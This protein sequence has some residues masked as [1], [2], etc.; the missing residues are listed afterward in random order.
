MTTN[1]HK[2]LDNKRVSNTFSDS[3]I[4]EQ[5]SYKISTNHPPTNTR[6]VDILQEKRIKRGRFTK[7]I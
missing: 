4:D 7:Y 6:N 2:V 3:K 5:F 1:D